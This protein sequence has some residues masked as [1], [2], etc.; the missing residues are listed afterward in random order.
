MQ[1]SGTNG[2]LLDYEGDDDCSFC[3]ACIQTVT[4]MSRFQHYKS[5]R[6]GEM[7]NFLNQFTF[8]EYISEQ[9]ASPKHSGPFRTH[10]HALPVPSSSVLTAIKGKMNQQ[11]ANYKFQLH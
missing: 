2:V 10:D 4:E 6:N 8:S 1:L 7:V 9:S 3:F 11:S 5:L